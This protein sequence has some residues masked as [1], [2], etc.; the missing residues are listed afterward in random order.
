M[1]SFHRRGGFRFP[2]AFFL[3]CGPAIAVQETWAWGELGHHVA[4]RVA[5]NYLTPTTRQEIQRLI[6]AGSDLVSISTWADEIRGGRPETRPWHYITLQVRGEQID[7]RDADK[8]NAVTAL[9]SALKILAKAGD[10]RARAEALRWVLHL[11]ADLHQ[12]LHAGEDH[13]KGGNQTKVRLKRRKMG[14]HQ[15]WDDGY[16]KTLGLDEERLTQALLDSARALDKLSPGLIAWTRV[17]PRDIAAES[18][19]L[20]IQAYHRMGRI[21]KGRGKAVTLEKSDIQ[22]GQAVSQGQLLKA[23]IRLA[24]ALNTAL[25][26]GGKV[27][28]TPKSRPPVN[29]G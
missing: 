9:D 23:G 26:P 8:P 20:A 4:A 12:P 16:L 1:T 7:L 15:V 28:S 13:D 5:E 21:I 14:W 2:I 11:M 17:S 10:D 24:A 6:G 18:H 27:L 25:D 3:V 29:G 19:E 22:W